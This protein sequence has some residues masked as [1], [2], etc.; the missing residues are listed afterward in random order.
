MVLMLLSYVSIESPRVTVHA[1]NDLVGG[2]LAQAAGWRWDYWVPALLDGTILLI[3]LFLLPET[4][5][6]R[7]PEFL[8]N[9]DHERSYMQMLF[10]FKGNLIP[11][12]KLK[13]E[14]FLHTIYMARYP[15]VS[16]P[17]VYYTM[18]WTFVNTMPAVTIANTFNK[19]YKFPAG[20][21]G[22][23]LGLS[24]LIGSTIAELVTGR[25]SDW[26]LYQDS[27]RHNGLRRPEARLYLTCLTA[28]AM[29]GGLIIYGW[30]V[31]YRTNFVAPL[32]GVAVGE[33]LVGVQV[34]QF[35][36]DVIG[37]FGLQMTATC[38]YSY[39]SDCY[40][41][42][43]MESGVLFNLGR[44]LAFVVGFFAIPYAE[45]DGYGW[46][47]FTFAM[48]TL[49]SFVPVA[50]LMKYGQRWRKRLGE[51]SFDRYI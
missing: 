30:C 22:L 14:S 44:G 37:G 10:N 50:L 8:A 42:Q 23:C 40:K 20:K 39:V 29:P 2:F 25:L 9:R 31:Q 33:F 24:L 35:A 6:S 26:I 13:A 36:N 16:I 51:P 3:A 47:W 5:F 4:L 49:L 48:I 7:H 17:A 46:A 1:D 38:C 11:A 27:K 28:L 21:T 18:G 43:T 32:V 19:V 41:P 15:S 12:R 45:K 34:W